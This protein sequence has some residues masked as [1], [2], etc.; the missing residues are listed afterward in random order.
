M[1]AP[2]PAAA[3]AAA[4]AQAIPMVSMLEQ[5]GFTNAVA[6]F[7]NNDEQINS[8]AHLCE[9]VPYDLGTYLVRDLCQSLRKPGTGRARNVPHRAERG[10]LFLAVVRND[11][12][13][14]E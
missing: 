2:V 5:L 12:E 3:D 14:L 6:R 8:L 1:A 10:L 11:Q 13:A 4:V 7:L 9:L